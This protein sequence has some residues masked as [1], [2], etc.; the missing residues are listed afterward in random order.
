M[1]TGFILYV[2]ERRRCRAAACRMAGSR[3]ALAVLVLASLVVAAS[4]ALDRFP[5]VTADLLARVMTNDGA[6]T[7]PNMGGMR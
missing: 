2:R 1:T 5:E 6:H 3:V 7:G 4:I